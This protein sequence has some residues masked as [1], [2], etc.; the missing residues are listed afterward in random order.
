MDEGT[1]S[2]NRI[3]R[4]VWIVYLTILVLIVIYSAVKHRGKS[5]HDEA[6]KRMGIEMTSP[7]PSN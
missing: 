2:S 3:S 1:P 7:K 6:L 5:T 4:N